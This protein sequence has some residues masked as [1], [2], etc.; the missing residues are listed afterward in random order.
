VTILTSEPPPQDPPPPDPTPQAEEVPRDYRGLILDLSTTLITTLPILVLVGI[1]SVT[2]DP[3][4]LRAIMSGGNLL[5]L[6]IT[7]IAPL[8]PMVIGAVTMTILLRI[9]LSIRA[10]LITFAAIT[11]TLAAMASPA[12]TGLTLITLPLAILGANE[13]FT[14]LKSRGRMGDRQP[15]NNYLEQTIGG[16]PP[17]HIGIPQIVA[18]LAMF[19]QLLQTTGFSFSEIP[20][21]A[22]TLITEALPAEVITIKEQG[23]AR[24]V[25]A[26]VIQTG[27]Q[28]TTIINSVG[29]VENLWNADITTRVACSDQTGTWDRSILMILSGQRSKTPSCFDIYESFHAGTNKKSGH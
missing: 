3:A 20:S 2:D 24:P 23:V 1:L 5:G 29:A 13:I 11:I 14:R 21:G 8:L 22:S 7:M 6:I 10:A 25:R 28:V 12:D 16:R 15:E 27:D 17:R 9:G 19:I 4:L 26:H 18:L